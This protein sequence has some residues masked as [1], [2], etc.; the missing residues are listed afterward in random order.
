[1][2]VVSNQLQPISINARRTEMAIDVHKIPHIPF[3]LLD[4]E[5]RNALT[6]YLRNGGHVQRYVGHERW[7]SVQWAGATLL[8]HATY[9]AA[10][11]PLRP[12]SCT[13]PGVDI[14]ELFEESVVALARDKAGDLYSYTAVPWRG[15]VTWHGN[16]FAN[17]PVSMTAIDPGNMPWNESLIVRPGWE[18]E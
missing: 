8:D 14:W 10:P 13:L 16:G 12:I 11:E 2:A 17:I 15:E 7:E 1:M 9:R 3:D 6:S 5:E 18:G 4:E